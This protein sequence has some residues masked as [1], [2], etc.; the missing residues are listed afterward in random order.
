M[1]RNKYK[2][3]AKNEID[4]IFAKIDELEAKKDMVSAETKEKV[5]HKIAELKSQR[6][7]IKSK[8][9]ELI[10]TTEESWEKAKSSFSESADSFKNG[11]SELTHL[12]RK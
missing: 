5:N 1:E 4:K 2:E 10:D 3:N 11:L 9:N 12:F 7:V 8:Y 6:D